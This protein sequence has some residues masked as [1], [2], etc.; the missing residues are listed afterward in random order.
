M[1]VRRSITLVLSLAMTG[2]AIYLAPVQAGGLTSFS[3]V[4]GISM[5]PLLHA[6]DL[7]VSRAAPAYHVGDVVLYKNQI[8]HRE[9][10]HRILKIQ[11]DRFFF[12]GD[13]N[14]FVDPAYATRGQLVGKM[15]FHVP[16][17]GS[18]LT[19][20]GK[21][22]HSAI[23]AAAISLLLLLGTGASSKRRKRR[24]R[25]PAAAA[26]RQN[27]FFH[28]PR[29]T[30]ENVA[31]FAFATLAALV[32][33]VG[34]TTPLHRTASLTGAYVQHGFFSYSGRATGLSDVY[35][36]GSVGTG[37]TIFLGSVPKLHVGFTYRFETPRPHGVKGTVE[38]RVLVSSDAI[39]WHDV[40]DQEAKSFSG[41]HVTVDATL[42]LARI[43]ALAQ[44]LVTA[45][46]AVG[47]DYQV[48]V[49]PLIK[50][51][52][53]VGKYQIKDTF[54]PTLP[55]S[56]TQ[57]LL[58]VVPAAPETLPGAS[59][60]TP[61]A[62]TLLAGALNPTKAGAIPGTTANTLSALRYRIPVSDMRGL[63]LG[64][65]ALAL[66]ALLLKPL[67]PKREVWS[68]ERRIAH[69]HGCIIVG[70][71]EITVS[72]ETAIVT[73]PR[74]ADLAALAEQQDEPIM[75]AIG[76]DRSSYAVGHGRHL[77][78]FEAPL[79]APA[80]AAT[81][82]PTPAP[83][84]APAPR[85]TRSRREGRPR[86]RLVHTVALLTFFALVGSLGLVF[87]AATTVPASNAG[88]VNKATTAA[89]LA[90]TACSGLALTGVLYVNTN[91]FNNT[92]SNML[93]VGRSVNDTITDSGHNN[94]V[95]AGGGQDNVNAQAGSVCL[96]NTNSK[97]V[98]KNCTK[99]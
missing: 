22:S 72:S 45:S 31:F 16:S 5:N 83:A 43:Q 37:Q 64:L 12:K 86:N 32:A 52:G 46:G 14:S 66:L 55:M 80:A 49:Q 90:P 67:R 26:R 4:D 69:Q 30:L 42:D 96:A 36:S 68:S 54:A 38:M 87:T 91:T 56:M 78:V 70:V 51:H 60:T 41:D 8:L 89:Q 79:P 39:S 82:A 92:Q 23:V 28:R 10:L 25:A 73:V 71:E 7:V 21:P 2:A 20:V 40:V 88:T 65:A 62:S 74:F 13:N 15:W 19:W 6:G 94:C 85:A 84:P 18:A 97:S 50:V 27:R 57:S 1:T 77:Y 81:P 59:Y 53:L 11:G 61:S 76:S 44:K 75:H 95:I 48:D 24:T 29:K 33:A 35:P 99:A 34:F 47:A 93:I 98:Y 9:V 58:K 3:V 17:A 63:A